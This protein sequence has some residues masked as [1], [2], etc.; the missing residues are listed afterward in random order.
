MEPLLKACG[1]SYS[2]HTLSGAT[3]AL[4]DISFTV[5]PGEFLAIVGPS[6]CGKST[7]LNLLSGLLSPEEGSIYIE[8]T[9]IREAR[10]GIGYMLQRDHLFEWRSIR[11]NAALGLEIR[12]QKNK[13]TLQELDEMLESYGLTAFAHAKPSELSGGMRQRAALIRT[14][15][16]KPDL[17]LL[18]EPFSALDYQTRLSV[19]DDIASII[20]DTKKTAI[21]ITHDLA[22][23]ISTADRV[24]VLSARPGRIR[25]EI[26]LSFS[27]Q[28]DSPLKRRNAPEFSGYF[29]QV[30]NELRS[31]M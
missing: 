30:W 3:P 28:Y 15:I 7:L 21:L 27:D 13:E 19:C 29:N 18:D 24:L 11:E 20:R 4:S 1:I 25:A 2:Y 9:P 10:S 22:E 8:D 14:L 31:S 5:S 23:A 17:L 16:L 26:P 12:H 6:G